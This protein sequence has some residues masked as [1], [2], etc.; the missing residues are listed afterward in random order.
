MMNLEFFRH[1]LADWVAFINLL[2][3][4]EVEGEGEVA[5]T[6]ARSV[7]VSGFEWFLPQYSLRQTQKRLGQKDSC[8]VI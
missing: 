8:L 6:A 5:A 1:F 7:G 4:V 3:D 2:V